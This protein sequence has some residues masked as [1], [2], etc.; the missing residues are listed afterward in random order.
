MGVVLSK[1][2]RP[3]LHHNPEIAGAVLRIF[4]RAIRTTLCSAEA[5]DIAHRGGVLNS[6]M[7]LRCGPYASDPG[8]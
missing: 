7:D 8:S 5:A 1:R 6:A 4:V 2:L 3:F